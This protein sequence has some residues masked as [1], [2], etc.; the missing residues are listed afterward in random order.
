MAA[1]TIPYFRLTKQ[2]PAADEAPLSPSG[3][4]TIDAM[5]GKY[6]REEKFSVSWSGASGTDK[7]SLMV[8]LNPLSQYNNKDR[9][10][11][12]DKRRTYKLPGVSW[13][14]NNL[15]QIVHHWGEVLDELDTQ[16]TLPLFS[17]SSVAEGRL[18]AEQNG[19]I[20]LLT[21]VTIAYLPLTLATSIYGMDA[22][23]NSAGLVSYIVVTILVSA[24]TYIIVYKIRR[25][26]DAVSRTRTSMHGLF[27]PQKKQDTKQRAKNEVI[28]PPVANGPSDM[29]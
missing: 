2:P 16:T 19:N 8:V 9:T 25:I 26:K 11:Y 17:A 3:A 1:F 4:F 13:L 21:M 27:H 29:A 24:I 15:F 10:R 22:L 12:M 20:R 5:G 28:N 18:A 6:I 14:R 7:A 23:P